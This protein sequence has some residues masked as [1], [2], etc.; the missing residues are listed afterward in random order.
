MS[1]MMSYQSGM[2]PKELLQLYNAPPL[3]GAVLGAAKGTITAVAP[4]SDASCF[5]A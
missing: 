5:L 2:A 3:R 1:S 4:M